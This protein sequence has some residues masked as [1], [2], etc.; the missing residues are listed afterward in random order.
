MKKTI[1]MQAMVAAA[2]TTVFAIRTYAQE[3]T[4]KADAQTGATRAQDSNSPERAF[5]DKDGDGVCDLVTTCHT[6][7]TACACDGQGGSRCSDF[8]DSDGDGVCD[9][10]GTC[11]RHPASACS[12]DR[13][14]YGHRTGTTNCQTERATNDGGKDAAETARGPVTCSGHRT[15][16]AACRRGSTGGCR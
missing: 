13:R 9:T 14:C 16:K 7:Q 5:V 12:P 15:G 6:G 4:A 8:R 2:L 1:M 11:Q 10:R 3:Q